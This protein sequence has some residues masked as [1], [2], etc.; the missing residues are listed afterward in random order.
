MTPLTIATLFPR[1]TVAAGDEAN[2]MALVRRARQRG[3]QATHTAV[4]RP[5]AMT[6]AQLYL[7]GGDGL[8]GVADLVAHLRSTN[9]A[10]EVRAGHA[11]VFAVDAGLAAVGRSWTDANGSLHEGLGLVGSTALAT[12]PWVASVVTRAVPRL[13]LPAMIGWYSHSFA[14]TRDKHVDQLAELVADPA[15]GRDLDGVITPG[16]IGTHLHGPVL[17]LNPELAD[18]V[19]AQAVGASGWDPLPVPSAQTARARRIAELRSRPPRAPRRR[20]IRGLL[21][22]G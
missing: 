22:R 9:M 13:G 6:P 16:V 7:L 5:E 15:G 21:Q 20:T 1:D 4:N 18:L 3:M 14:V 12:S 10:G 2:A 11:M 19:L 17:A 8:A